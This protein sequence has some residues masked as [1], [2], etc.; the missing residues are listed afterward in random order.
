VKSLKSE[1]GSVR[2]S[3]TLLGAACVAGVILLALVDG[4]P[5]AAA[6]LGLLTAAGLA[7][8]RFTVGGGAQDGG[9]RKTVRLLG[10]RAP[11][12]GEW[13][14]IV[15]RALGDQGELYFATTLRPQLQRL[16]AARLAERHGIEMHR[17]PEEAAS[18]VGPEVWPWIDP[19]EPPPAARPTEPVLRTLLDRLEALDVPTGPGAA[20]RA[21]TY[22]DQGHRAR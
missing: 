4:I 6:G 13:E 5:A 20:A 19:A 16:F 14:W 9:Y 22:P 15:R 1:P 18:L 3:L 8:A 17:A 2:H 21:T 12:L 10:S 11:A 7:V